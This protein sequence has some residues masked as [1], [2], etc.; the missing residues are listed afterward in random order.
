MKPGFSGW[1]WRPRGRLPAV[2]GSLGSAATGC[3]LG[4]PWL[5]ERRVPASPCCSGPKPFRV[6]HLPLLGP[7]TKM[8][9]SECIIDN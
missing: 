7:I 9:I 1:G 5:V 8:Q 4:E 3:R 2:G 6:F